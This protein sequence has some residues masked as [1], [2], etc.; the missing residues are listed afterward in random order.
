MI[1]FG[2]KIICRSL[3]NI[4]FK[5]D[6]NISTSSSPS[7]L[8]EESICAYNILI[9]NQEDVNSYD[10]VRQFKKEELDEFFSKPSII[11]YLS[12]KEVNYQGPLIWDGQKRDFRF[13][14]ATNYECLPDTSGLKIVNKKGKGLK[15]TRDAGRFSNLFNS[16]NWEWK[17]SFSKLPSKY[18]PIACNLSN[19]PVAL[20]AD[21]GEGRVFIIPTP[22]INIY[23]YNKYPTF[24]RQLIDVCEEEI[25][26]LGRRER[27]EPDWVEEQVD[28]LESKFLHEWFPFYERYSA[29]REARKLFYETGL[30]LT[31]VVHFVVSKMGFDAEMKEQEGVQDIEVCEDDF[32]SVIEV[33]SSEN[34]WINI[35]KTRQLLDW[36]HRF[37][38][39][40]NKKAKGILIANHFC[41][42]PPTQ[43]DMPF[44]REGLKQGEDEGFCLMTTVDL[45]N[46]FCKFLKNEIKK[47]EIKRLFLDTKG[48]LKF[49]G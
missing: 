36:C 27:K 9:V 19:I 32:N 21:I 14:T 25:E 13:E 18:T 37:E 39:E 17:C 10:N 4:H 48:L 5:Q 38:R 41:N 20:R 47:A 28:P 29:L 16:R 23:D 26:E 35:R 43:R 34:D 1:K 12:D 33:T 7:I 11:V 49:E 3:A 45:Y 31:R 30:G 46:I 8:A 6:E 40:Q 42:H 44:T 15:P 22:D 24:L 2:V